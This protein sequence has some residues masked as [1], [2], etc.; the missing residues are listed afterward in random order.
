MLLMLLDIV[1]PQVTEHIGVPTEMVV[2]PVPTGRKFEAMPLAMGPNVIVGTVMVPTVMSELL[3][4]TI[5]VSPPRTF[6]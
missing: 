6:P 5:T 3:M 1:N 4:G 2:I